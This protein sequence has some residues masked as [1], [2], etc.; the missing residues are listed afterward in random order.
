MSNLGGIFG[1]GKVQAAQTW[2]NRSL[3]YTHGYGVALGPVNRVTGEGLPYLFVQD[4]PPVVSDPTHLGIDR[5]EIYYGEEMH[6]PVFVRTGERE[7]DYPTAD[8]NAY[9]TYEGDGGVPVGSFLRRA[10]LAL[11]LGSLEVL[12]SSDI[13]AGSRLLLYRQ[14]LQRVERIAPF[15]WID[16]DPYMAIADGRLVWILD[17]Y[18][19]SDRFPYSAHRNTPITQRP[20]GEAW[21]P[22]STTRPRT[23]N[24]LRNSVKVVVDAY[25]GTVQ[26][27][28]VDTSDPIA[29]SW[30]AAF[31]GLFSDIGTMSDAV[32]E[33][34]RY[35]RTLFQMQGSLFSTFHMTDSKMFYNRE[36][37]WELPFW[38]VQA[39]ER[40]NYLGSQNVEMEPY[41]TIMKLPGEEEEEF[42]LMLPFVPKGKA[43]LAAWMV[44]RS[45]SDAYGGLRVYRF[46]KDRLIYG[47]G[48]IVSRILQNDLISEKLT[49]WNQQTSE[50]E[51]GTLLVIPVEESLVYLRP[52]YLRASS[53]A[54]P[55]LKRVLVAYENRIAMAPTLEEGLQEIFGVSGTPAAADLPEI[56][57]LPDT[58]FTT[59]DDWRSLADEAAHHYEAALEASRTGRWADFGE[60]LDRL[61]EQLEAL[62]ITAQVPTEPDNAPVPDDAPS[63]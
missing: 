37:E 14:V 8:G 59:S 58:T 35:P 52:L 17:A 39:N 3:V 15:L 25:D 47:P 26:L 2:V 1:S 43:N 11:R 18:T 36:D 57:E 51:L 5:P 16:D 10:M 34:L 13:H 20:N 22:R 61:G 31:P 62:R 40:S 19:H 38:E 32:R 42:I 4:I 29:A 60:E 7:F 41:Y 56:V 28:R 49:L 21:P 33:H 55:E 50:A 27:Y 9:T 63:P 48:Q 54:I 24:Y 45:D 46:P 23:A 30:D 12:L 6:H 44:A 53:D